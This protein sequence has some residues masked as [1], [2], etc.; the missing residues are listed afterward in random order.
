MIMK[1]LIVFLMFL[2]P[3]IYHPVP[4]QT[5]QELEV[6]GIVTDS[7][8]IPIPGVAVLVPESRT[9]TTTDANGEFKITVSKNS[10]LL[11]TCLGYESLEIK[12]NR[13]HLEIELNEDL[14][15]I[16]EVVV[17]GYGTTTR[18]NLT[19]AIATVKPESISKASNSNMSQLLLG[20]AGCALP[21]CV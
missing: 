14:Q 1:R 8:D 18:K 5:V 11:F 17:V 3:W 2:G 12:A 9:G 16:D 10:R 15:S 7:E 19:T 20:R 21:G 6:T 13:S 4:A